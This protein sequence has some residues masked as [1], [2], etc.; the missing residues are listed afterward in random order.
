MTTFELLATLRRRW[1]VVLFCLV[2]TVSAMIAIAARPGVH[3]TQV[4][5][6][7]LAPRSTHQPSVVSLTPQSL[8]AAAGLVERTIN[9]DAAKPT[10]TS[11]SVTLATEGI[12]RGVSITLPDS[13]GQWA[14]NFDRPAL[15]VQVIGPSEEWVRDRLAQAIST[16]NTTLRTIQNADGIVADNQIRTASAP[17]KASVQYSAGNPK[18]ALAATLLLGLGLTVLAAVG[19][20][21]AVTR[22]DELESWL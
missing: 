5:V 3:W 2:L 17:A 16:I 4:N 21:R 11:S 13:G 18:R 6:V 10:L 1:H 9:N 8:I 14:H 7:F 19:L 20:D 15:S 22:Q 12:R